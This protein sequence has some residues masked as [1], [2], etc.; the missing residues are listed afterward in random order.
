[1]GRVEAY[2]DGALAV[3]AGDHVGDGRREGVVRTQVA[4]SNHDLDDRGANQGRM[5]LV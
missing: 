4:R 3:G 2:G 5:V 1:M